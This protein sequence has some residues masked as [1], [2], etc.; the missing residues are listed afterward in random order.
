MPH[1][2]VQVSYTAEGWATLIKSP[3]NRI[4]QVRPA[5]EQAGGKI[6]SAYFAFGEYDVVLFCEFPDNTSAAGMAMSF[7]AGGSLRS[8]KT[9]P[10]LTP[11]EAVAAMKKAGGSAYKPAS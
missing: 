8:V 7:A 1:Y 3:Q 9:T 11:D 10:L 2:L 5:V 6:E 4:D